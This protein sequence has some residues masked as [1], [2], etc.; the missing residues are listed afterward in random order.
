VLPASKRE[1]EGRGEEGKEEVSEVM[2]V[3]GAR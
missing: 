2:Q 1:E 3:E